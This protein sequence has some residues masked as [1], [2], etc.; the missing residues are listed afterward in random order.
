[1]SNAAALL[2]EVDHPET[3]S[4]GEQLTSFGH[5]EFSAVGIGEIAQ[6]TAAM[7][8]ACSFI[9]GG[10]KYFAVQ[11]KASKEEYFR[12][13][14]RYIA[15]TFNMTMD[16]AFGF[17]ESNERLFHKYLLIEKAYRLGYTAAQDDSGDDDH[18]HVHFKNFYERYQ[19]VTM[20]DL[21]IEGINIRPTE[22]YGLGGLGIARRAWKRR[23]RFKRTLFWLLLAAGIVL[24]NIVLISFLK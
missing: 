20:S 24:F 21:D 1:M 11:T 15:E 14:S 16:N 6:S 13:L 17:V 23:S 12:V 5:H 4:L 22:A 19:H 10:L 7:V 2:P 9:A 8:C 3:D 18:E